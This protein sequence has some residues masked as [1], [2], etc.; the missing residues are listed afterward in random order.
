MPSPNRLDSDIIAQVHAMVLQSKAA[1]LRRGETLNVCFFVN[2]KQFWSMQSVYDAFK[3]HT[4]FN[5]LIV[6]FPIT[7]DT[8]DGKKAEAVDYEELCE[9]HEEKGAKVVRVCEPDGR[10]LIGPD[11]LAPDI[12]FY[13]QHWMSMYHEEY[14]IEHMFKSALCVCVP[15]GVMIAN[16]PENQFNGIAHNFAW[17]N[18]VESPV[19]FGLAMKYGDNKGKNAVV[20]GYPKFDA[21]S[22]PVRKSY[23]KTS[24]P[25]IKRIIWAPH[26]SVNT[27][28]RVDFA[29]FT[30]YWGKMLEFVKNNGDKIEMIMKPHPALRSQCAAVGMP[31]QVFDRYVDI[32][33]SLPNGSVVSDGDYIDLFMTSDAMILDS[34]SFISEYMITGKPMCFLNKFASAAELLTH[35]N[36][37]GKKAVSLL[38]MA[39]N[40]DDVTG[41]IKGVC[42]GTLPEREDRKYFV[43][44]ILKVNFGHVGEFMVNHILQQLRA[45]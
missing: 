9:F 25:Q 29:T 17:R 11:E 3:K 14:S 22:G 13:E 32:W 20:S 31:G 19:H 1:V 23:W 2:R 5:L 33:N 27:G 8:P 45:A 35:F 26:Y 39:Y 34:L 28:S 40:W 18:F 43:D 42:D 10:L 44:N 38:D 4:R 7:L 36:D 12:I 21:F 6:P 37:Y 41:F 15:Y 16:I 30:D 24:S